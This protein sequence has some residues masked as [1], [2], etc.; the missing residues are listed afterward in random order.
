MEFAEA[1][2]ETPWL[3]IGYSGAVL[4]LGIGIWLLYRAKKIKREGR[5]KHGE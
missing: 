5:A 3:L 1:E 4:L 2:K